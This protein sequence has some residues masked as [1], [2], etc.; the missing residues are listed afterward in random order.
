VN[1]T[2]ALAPIS[3]KTGVKVTQLQF[4][5]TATDVDPGQAKT[6]SLI[7]APTGAAINATTGAFS[8]TPAVTGTFTFK[9]RVTD[10]GSPVLYKEQSVTVTVT[11]AALTTI[12][13]NTTSATS[14]QGETKA[15]KTRTS[16][17]PNPVISQMTIT[18]GAP[19][20]QALVTIA[21]LK[22]AVIYS[23]IQA[24]AEQ[25]IQ[26]DATP[27]KPGA[28]FMQVQSTQGTEVLKFVKL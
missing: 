17:Y 23:K 27:F 2:P 6:F 28:Y 16:V 7:G 24:V 5:A 8:W 4:I 12:S 9:V 3:N 26:L 1:D 10:N 25:Q 21:D 11:T 14:K 22:G 20:T 18:F 13:V 19:V 15:I